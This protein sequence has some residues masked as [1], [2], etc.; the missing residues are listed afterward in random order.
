MNFS[1]KY[2]P[3]PHVRQWIVL[4]SVLFFL[5]CLIALNL[6]I[7]HQ[8]TFD[9]ESSKLATQA[10][11][12]V[13]NL[14]QQLTAAGHA[15][16][17]AAK[18]LRRLDDPSKLQA[19]QVQLTTISDAIPGI[20]DIG[21]LNEKGT[22]LYST[23]ASLIGKNFSYR[24]YFQTAKRQPNEQTLYISKPFYNVLGQN[25][26]VLSRAITSEQVAFA[27]VVVA[28]LDAAYFSTL[29]NS[30]LYAPDMSDYVLHG[31]GDLFLV[32]P[33]DRKLGAKTR[34]TLETL[35]SQN[36]AS[37]E[38]RVFQVGFEKKQMLVSQREVFSAAL[39]MNYP[40][41]VAVSRD[42]DEVYSEWRTDAWIQLGFF[43]LICLISV[44]GL[45]VYQRKQG[46]LQQ[47]VVES[48][49][50]A[51]R[52]SLALDRIPAYIFLKDRQHRYV[53]A[54][55]PTLE[56]FK[57]DQQTLQGCLDAQFFPAKTAAKLTQIDARVFETGLDNAEQVDVVDANGKHRVY[58][59][60]KTPVM[61]DVDPTKVWGLCGISSDIT[62][63]KEKERALRA[64]E[65]RFH[66]IFENA[67]I[68][69][70]IL[71][72][73]GGF[74]QVNTS[75]CRILGYTAQEL[76]QKTFQQITH[77][78]DLQDD[79]AWMQKLRDGE[80]EQYQ[81]EK[82]YIHQD[83]HLIWTLLSRSVVRDEAENT[84]YFIAQ[85]QDIT[86]QKRINEQLSQQAK[87]DYLTNLP[88]RRY[89]ME[90]AEV[91]LDRAKR[92]SMPL[93]MLMIDI[94]HFK[95]IND[96]YGHQVGDQVL[97]QLGRMM[98]TKL[99]SVD[100][101]GRIGGE[102]FAILLPDSHLDH[103]VQVAERIRTSLEQADLVLENGVTVRCTVSV[104]VAQL[105]PRDVNLDHLFNEADRALYAAKNKQRNC[106]CA[107]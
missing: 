56:L 98:P 47:K 8:R 45:L 41:E 48:Q 4:I 96:T 15:L 28:T 58:W 13:E 62:E 100:I 39:G 99:R 46:L 63:I 7:S 25:V 42:L 60:V 57:C 65:N 64:S 102:E 12:I 23:A 16:T 67:P 92:Y 10:S 72:P 86:E 18:A 14:Q 33:T 27:G 36:R 37:G 51:K 11:V 22:M 24:E 43:C 88:N 31:A 35:F 29:M 84:Y 49:A 94:D 59:E 54:N 82:R 20:R 90:R 9:R 1:H 68:G 70:A 106:V 53:Y 93:S 21:I 5:A 104:G 105:N 6:Y 97:Q 17:S 30:V 78:E 74:L 85:I 80:I 77:A 40:I 83:G 55:R 52:L 79:L 81:L 89:F 95:N 38:N 50:H 19:V 34:A 75:L 44:V 3:M 69:M 101:L 61:D 87:L 73:E 32:E 71:G 66:S 103:A 2:L 91:E 107:A 76:Q 26:I